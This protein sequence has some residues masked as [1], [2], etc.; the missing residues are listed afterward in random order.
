[1]KSIKIVTHSKIEWLE[2]RVKDLTSTEVSALFGLSPYSTYFETWHNKKS[3][4]YTTIG[5]N[6]RMSWG[7]ALESSIAIEAG[8][9]NNWTEVKERKDYYRIEE[10]RLGSSF[11]YEAIVDGKPTIVEVKNVD[12]FVFHENWKE[13][14]EG[15][16]EAPYHIELQLQYQLLV[17]GYEQGIITALVGGNKLVTLLRTPD[18]AMHAKIIETAKEFWS[19][20]EENKIPEANYEK[21]AEFIIKMYQAVTEKKV[22]EGSTYIAQMALDYKMATANEN[23]C[24]ADK[25]A[26]KAKIFEE[27]DDAE[28]V[29]G[30]VD[31]R[32]YSVSCGMRK[33]GNRNFT[34]YLAKEK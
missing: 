5:E 10:L 17:S 31:G 24:K 19:S 20:I 16:I 25:K 8:R 21:D 33:D 30:T 26:I 23:T 28:K 1:M 18:L 22:I 7:N 13:D 29:T 11:D 15:N 14:Q 6:E 4:T 34:V 3:Q 12:G 9:V 27:I 2:E 32:K